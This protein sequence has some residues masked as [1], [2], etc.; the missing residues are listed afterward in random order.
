MV[1]KSLFSLIFLVILII[2]YTFT[3]S[4]T[5]VTITALA[6]IAGGLESDEPLAIGEGTAELTY[7]SVSNKNVKGQL[8]ILANIGETSFIEIYRAFIKARFPAFRLTLGKTK[9]SWGEGFMFNAGDL[10]FGSTGLSVDITSDELRNTGAWLSSFYFSLGRFSFIEAV[11]FPPEINLS[12]LYIDGRLYEENLIDDPPRYPT[13]DNSKAGVRFYTKLK[14]IKFEGG[15]LLNGAKSMHSVY[16]SSQ[17]NLFVD[18]YLS[19]SSEIDLNNPSQESF[20]N[21]L[22]ISTGLFHI[23]KPTQESSINLRFESLIYPLGEWNEIENSQPLNQNLYGLYLYPEI[24]YSPISGQNYFLRAIISP[25]DTSG[26]VS[27]GYSWNIYQGF[28]ILS[29]TGVQF[30]DDSDSFSI[31][32]QGGWFLS[33]GARFTF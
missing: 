32:K 5:S 4:K 7:K 25:I 31:D 14:E 29:Y 17:G 2:G 11:Y 21:N 30:G 6:G 18:W 12:K 15:Y 24:S 27:L 20:K 1:R 23:I 9:L 8:S 10:L 33:L 28:T 3:E 13:A 16:F 22:K 19:S 26:L